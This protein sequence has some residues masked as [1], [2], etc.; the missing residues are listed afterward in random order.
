MARVAAKQ[1][2]A[3]C[4]L[5]RAVQSLVSLFR[6]AAPAQLRSELAGLARDAVGR[7]AAELRAGPARARIHADPGPP[8]LPR[9]GYKRFAAAAAADMHLGRSTSCAKQ[10]PRVPWHP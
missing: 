2:K 7:R 4:C 5:L 9:R 1:N 3:A 10:T 6:R 8:A